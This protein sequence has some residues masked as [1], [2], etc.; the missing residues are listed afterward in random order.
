MPTSSC[1][2]GLLRPSTP[3]VSPEKAVSR[4]DP[5]HIRC[6]FMQ[7]LCN[8]C[9]FTG[10]RANSWGVQIFQN[11]KSA[12]LTDLGVIS[13]TC[14]F[15]GQSGLLQAPRHPKNS[16]FPIGICSV[17]FWCSHSDVI[18]GGLH[19]FMVRED[20]GGG[21]RLNIRRYEAPVTF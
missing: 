3:R 8:I 21:K 7:P 4:L 10:V 11:R 13:A 12:D 15:G 1:R 2:K 20:V 16:P 17:P 14:K 6:L 19:A 5:E 18:A 9:D